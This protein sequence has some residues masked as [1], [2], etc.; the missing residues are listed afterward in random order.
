MNVCSVAALVSNQITQTTERSVTQVTHKLRTFVAI[1]VSL[2]NVFN[3]AAV[4]SESFTANVTLVRLF[5][6][7]NKFVLLKGVFITEALV[8]YRADMLLFR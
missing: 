5:L 2:L 6:T 4:R 7:M 3:Q 8:A 1:H